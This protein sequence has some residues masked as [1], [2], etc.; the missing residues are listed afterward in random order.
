MPTNDPTRT[1]A[2][3]SVPKQ[4]GDHICANDTSVPG[5]DSSADVVLPAG[6]I[7][8]SPADAER[9][10]AAA[11]NSAGGVPG[12]EILGELGKG[13]MGVVYKARHVKLNRVVALKMV[14]GSA[15]VGR[16]ELIRFLAE[17]ESVAAIKHEN[18][19]QVFDYGDANGRPFMALEF[20]SGGSLA[21][22]L[23]KGR[24]SVSS[25]SS[26]RQAA[27]LLSQTARGVAA[28]HALGIVHRDLK[29][30]NVLLDEAGAPKV[31]DF[32]LAKRGDGSDVTQTGQVMGTPA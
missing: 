31:A 20:L 13:G 28:A 2:R 29:P 23:E 14:L 11:S 9:I 22:L 25:T 18:V 1:T 4:T 30:A 21:K 12:Y 19:V 26:A 7:I 10:L 17:A 3:E 27:K 15:A 24:E 6:T 5:A 16:S 32:G 8:Q